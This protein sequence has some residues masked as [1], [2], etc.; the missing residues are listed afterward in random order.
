MFLVH[1]RRNTWKNTV[2]EKIYTKAK[3]DIKSVSKLVVQKEK[4]EMKKVALQRFYVP[5]RKYR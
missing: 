3:K 2:F 4:K 1:V 5:K